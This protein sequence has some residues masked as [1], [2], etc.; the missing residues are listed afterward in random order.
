MALFSSAPASNLEEVLTN[1]AGLQTAGIN[2]AYT[3]KRKREVARLAASGQLMGGTADYPLADLSKEEGGALS[4]V[5]SSLAESLGQIPAEDWAFTREDQRKRQLAKLIGELT[6]REGGVL[7]GITGALGG[8][9][10]GIPLM[11][12]G[13]VPAGL[14]LSGLGAGLGAYGGSQ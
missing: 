9:S 12:T 13:N 2:D 8:F 7:G 6:R 11:A 10:M 1:Q 14:A 4:D 3:Q 5:Q